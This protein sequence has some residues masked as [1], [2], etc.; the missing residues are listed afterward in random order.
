[1]K[2]LTI[3]KQILP[4]ELRVEL[5]GAIDEDSDFKELEGLQQ[6]NISFDFNQISMINSCGIREW[7]KFLEHM[8]EESNIVYENCPQIIIEQINMVHGFF[9]KGASIRSFYAPYY[10]EQCDKEVKIHLLSERVENRQAP[11]INCPTCG[12]NELEFDAIESQYFSFL[13][14]A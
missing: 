10:C 9:K 6:K 1:V 5:V 8:P 11:K 14:K 7:I 4:D 3:N 2:R 13:G 12:S